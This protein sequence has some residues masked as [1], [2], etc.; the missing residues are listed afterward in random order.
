MKQLVTWPWCGR[1]Y[2]WSN[3][4]NTTSSEIKLVLQLFWTTV[5][6]NTTANPLA[7]TTSD[8]IPCVV[9][10]EKKFLPKAYIFRLPRLINYQWAM[11]LFQRFFIG[12]AKLARKT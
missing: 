8:H 9:S 10:I 7:M 2:T 4:Q 11:S 3:M 1:K 5:Y 6:P 12:C